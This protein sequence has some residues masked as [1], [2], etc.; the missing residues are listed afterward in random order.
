[1]KT[2]AAR[3]L[4]SLGIGHELRNYEV[5]PEDLAAE[6]CRGE[7]WLLQSGFQDV[8]GAWRSLRPA[9]RGNPGQLRTGLQEAGDAEWRSQ[10]RAGRAE[11][12]PAADRL[13]PRRGD[14][15]GAKKDYP[16]FADETIELWDVISISAGVR[17]T[18]ILLPPA[19]YL[20]MTKATVGESRTRRDASSTTL[21]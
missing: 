1:M 16:V 2:N 17:G 19:D 14:C 12:S 10:G 6:T 4:D 20:R 18:Q 9:L 15:S 13:Y 21:D 5:D 7:G 3:L 8:A 11:R